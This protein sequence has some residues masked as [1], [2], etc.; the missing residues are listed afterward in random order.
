MPDSC[1]SPPAKL[2]ARGAPVYPNPARP[3]HL[4]VT[5]VPWISKILMETVPHGFCLKLFAQKVPMLTCEVDRGQRS[6]STRN[7]TKGLGGVGVGVAHQL[8]S[9]HTI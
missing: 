4:L 3:S 1:S 2:P 8:L 5:A 7:S 9:K 6:H